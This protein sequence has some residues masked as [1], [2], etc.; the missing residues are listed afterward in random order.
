MATYDTFTVDRLCLLVQWLIRA[1]VVFRA[2]FC[3]VKLMIADED[4]TQYR[5]RL[6]NGVGFL[7]LSEIVFSLKNIVI[8][9]YA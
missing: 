9:Y 5:R 1:G 8:S 4:A 2:V 3:L 7:V 6:K